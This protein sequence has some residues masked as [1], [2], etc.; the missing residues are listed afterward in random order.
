MFMRSLQK[1]THQAAR[2]SKL[3]KHMMLSVLHKE[4]NYHPWNPYYVQELQPAD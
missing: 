2:E 1:S 4:L 3:T